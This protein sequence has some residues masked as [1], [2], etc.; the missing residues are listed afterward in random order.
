MSPPS[1]LPELVI[2]DMAGTTVRDQGEVPQAFTAALAAFDIA[3]SADQVAAVRGA[4]KRQAVFD[5]T[6][7]GPLRAARAAAIYERFT[8][9]L[10]QRFAEGAQPVA[11]AAQ[12]FAW[13]RA[14]SVKMA[15]N[16]GF[17]RDITG[18]LLDALGWAEGIVNAVVCGDEVPQGRPA[19]YLIFRCL[20]ATGT[21]SIHRVAVVGDTALDLQAAHNAG[22]HWNVGVLSG[23]HSRELLASQPHTHLVPSVAQLPGLWKDEG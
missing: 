4:S 16:T 6:P 1:T 10:A 11:G 2:F 18:L 23:A 8:E 19:P 5:L 9:E 22:V 3:V 20:E 17:D 21:H 15:L 14:Q 12:T 13:L 7:D